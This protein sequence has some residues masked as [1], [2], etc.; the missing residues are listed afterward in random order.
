MKSLEPAEFDSSLSKYECCPVKMMKIW[1]E[2]I[3]KNTDFSCTQHDAGP[4]RTGT[5]RARGGTGMDCVYRPTKQT[6]GWQEGWRVCHRRLTEV[7]YRDAT[8]LDPSVLTHFFLSLLISL[9]FCF[10][11][12]QNMKS[13]LK[14]RALVFDN[15]INWRFSFQSSH[16]LKWK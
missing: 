9:M 11:L 12:C 3:L 4:A 7:S 10:S 1:K 15:L 8:V 14:N 5:I 16:R 6:S 2:G 13:V